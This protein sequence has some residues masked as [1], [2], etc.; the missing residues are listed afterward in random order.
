MTKVFISII[1]I[2]I[3]VV[4]GVL[5]WRFWPPEEPIEPGGNVPEGFYTALYSPRPIEALRYCDENTPFVSGGDPPILYTKSYC[6]CTVARYV[7]ETDCGEAIE[8]CKKIDALEII[9]PPLT[10]CETTN[11]CVNQLPPKCKP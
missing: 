2:F 3:I 7:G 9:S 5:I 10:N 1:F 4:A 8:V 6:Y 11:D